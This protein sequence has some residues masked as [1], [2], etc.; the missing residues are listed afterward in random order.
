MVDPLKYNVR[1][2]SIG[3]SIPNNFAA[4]ERMLGPQPKINVSESDQ[5]D[6]MVQ[7]QISGQDKT[8]RIDQSASNRVSG[9][10]GVDVD[11]SS[12]VLNN[13]LSVG[14]GNQTIERLVPSPEWF[15]GTLPEHKIREQYKFKGNKTS[16]VGSVNIS[17]DQG[18][19]RK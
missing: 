9:I 4:M 11:A 14:T 16:S 12:S 19:I 7:R 6:D 15:G 13:F 3:D 1:E 18:G 5:Y 2:S 17:D 10:Y 8:K